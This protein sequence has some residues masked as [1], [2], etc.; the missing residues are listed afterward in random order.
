MLG[1]DLLD[2]EHD[3]F[4]KR[5]RAATHPH[6]AQ[7]LAFGCVLTRGQ[8]TSGPRNEFQ[9]IPVRRRFAVPGTNRSGEFRAAVVEN[10]DVVTGA[11]TGARVGE[12]KGPFERDRHPVQVR[13]FCNRPGPAQGF[14]EESWREENGVFHGMVRVGR[15]GFLNGVVNAVHFVMP[16]AAVPMIAPDEIENSQPG[17]IQRHVEII[18]QLV[19]K[20]A[21]VGA[22][23]SAAAIVGAPHVRPRADALI[24]PAVPESVSIKTHR[25]QRGLRGA[26]VQQQKHQ[27]QTV[28]ASPGK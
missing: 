20:M 16:G 2:L 3:V 4:A 1:S 13:P 8:I 17:D 27:Q 21:G 24:G 23:V 5:N 28:P 15:A 10:V 9:H 6:Q 26:S 11:V 14:R 25:N 18:G 22:F 7:C 12:A 19:Q